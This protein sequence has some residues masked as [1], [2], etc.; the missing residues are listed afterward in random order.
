M[1]TAKYLKNVG[2]TV[3][4]P[5]AFLLILVYIK[6]SEETIILIKNQITKMFG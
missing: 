5:L 6:N 2:K 4:K 1:L 3:K